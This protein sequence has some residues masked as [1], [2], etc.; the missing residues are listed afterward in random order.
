MVKEHQL[1]YV[2]ATTIN[3]VARSLA[4]Q[5]KVRLPKIFYIL[6]NIGSHSCKDIM[7][8]GASCGYGRLLQQMEQ[9]QQQLSQK[10]QEIERLNTLLAEKEQVQ[11]II[12]CFLCSNLT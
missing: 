2:R 6:S 12:V 11:K 10:D 9:L 3:M 7:V 5:N 8:H 4:L 1:Q